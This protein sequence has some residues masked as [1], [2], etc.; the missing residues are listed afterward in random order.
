[1]AP[2]S[3]AATS[4]RSRRSRPGGSQAAAP[5]HPRQ[6]DVSSTILFRIRYRLVGTQRA[7][8]DR[9]S[10][11]SAGYLDELLPTDPDEPRM[12]MTVARPPSTRR[13]PCG[14][15][16]E[17]FDLRRTSGE[18]FTCEYGLFPLRGSGAWQR[19][20]AIRRVVEGGLRRPRSSTACS[21][22]VRTARAA[23]E[24]MSRD[25]ASQAKRVNTLF[26]LPPL[27][28]E[29]LCFPGTPRD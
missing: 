13:R 22:P 19:H 26:T 27:H 20:R 16:R 10:T 8:G 12:R 3:P 2:A 6:R 21:D 28:H 24:E 14:L 4:P 25:P 1:M 5:Q 15:R 29:S 18:I 17:F 11:S 9:L 7:R 23:A